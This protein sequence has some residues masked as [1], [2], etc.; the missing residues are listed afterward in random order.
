M[1]FYRRIFTVP[2]FQR[3]VFL[4]GGLCVVWCIVTLF[5]IIFQCSPVAAAWNIIAQLTGAGECM[6]A[7][8]IVFGSELANVV[9]DVM[10]LSLPVYMV[11]RLQLP[12][13]RKW[14]VSSI[15]LLGGLYVARSCPSLSV[16]PRTC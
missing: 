11:R 3:W 6:P 2:S 15:F 5:L 13:R 16:C 7:S 14:G 4:L 1:C 12:T 10:I 8:H 9:L